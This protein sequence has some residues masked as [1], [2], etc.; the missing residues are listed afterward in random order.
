M[1]EIFILTK[2]NILNYVRD[3]AS[4]FFSLLSVII[5]LFIY[6]L[7]LKNIFTEMEGI[8]QLQRSIFSLG[9]IMGGLLVVSTITL[10]LGV[11]GNYVYDLDTK[12]LNGILV[13]PISRYKITLAYCLSTI[14]VTTI[15]TLIMFFLAFFYLGLFLGSWYGFFQTLKI[16][17]VLILYVIISSPIM[18]FI[19][20]FVK[21][22][23]AFGA[24]S[25]M[26][27]TLIGFL[28]GIYIP[29][30]VLD[31]FTQ[32][33]A[34]LMPFSHMTY[35]LRK[36]LIGDFYN[37][38]PVEVLEGAGISQVKLFGANVPTAWALIVSLIVGAGFFIFA[39]I[40]INKKQT[41]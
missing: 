9:Y 7:F 17:G 32:N 22:I 40:K 23:N 30:T 13:T 41:S 37:D 31:P 3:K 33:I 29:L 27:G 5:L 2:R 6:L 8:T 12:K 21:S 11:M 1:K 39:Y 10:S 35:Y 18:I 19:I 34:G 15:L 38:I 20:S 16:V 26:V 4:V 14:I 28:S 24:V 36:L 25:S